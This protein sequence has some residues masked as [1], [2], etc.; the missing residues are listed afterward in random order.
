M[1]PCEGG[2]TGFHISYMT[3]RH[4]NK[5]CSTTDLF[6]ANSMVEYELQIK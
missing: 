1:E 3:A 6:L 5:M 2:M 4:K